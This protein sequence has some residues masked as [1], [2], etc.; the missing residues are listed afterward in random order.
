MKKILEGPS[1]RAGSIF[2]E[3]DTNF[4]EVCNSILRI[5]F[6]ECTL[7]GYAETEPAEPALF[8][9]YLVRENAT[10]WEIEVQKDQ[11]LSWDGAEWVIIPFKITEINQALQFMYFDAEKIAVTSIPGMDATNVQSALEIIIAALIGA[12][13]EIPSSGSGSGS[14]IYTD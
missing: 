8:D 9:S 12:E 3:I 5:A 7:K 14:A 2:Q 1:R 6:P 13:I 10:L 11:V 4:I